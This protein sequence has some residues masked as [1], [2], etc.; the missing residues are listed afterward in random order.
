[1]FNRSEMNAPFKDYFDV[2]GRSR[3][4]TPRLKIL[5]AEDVLCRKDT[6]AQHDGKQ[7][8][9]IDK[10]HLSVYGSERCCESVQA[11]PGEL[12]R[13]EDGAAA[14]RP[15]YGGGPMPAEMCPSCRGACVSSI[16]RLK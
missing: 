10:D 14:A 4:D 12:I 8:F 16:F 1:M 15:E 5:N 3:S 9:Y 7:Y 2:L 11:V 6:C 13:R